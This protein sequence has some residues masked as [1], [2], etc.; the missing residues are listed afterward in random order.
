MPTP[1]AF[2]AAPLP[3]PTPGAGQPRRYCNKFCRNQA[4]YGRRDDISPLSSWPT[5]LVDVKPFR[6]TSR[7]TLATEELAPWQPPHSC[8]SSAYRPAQ[9]R[10]AA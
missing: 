7:L 6:D 8:R 3:E 2:C 9:S 10:I 5:W 1:C 4:S